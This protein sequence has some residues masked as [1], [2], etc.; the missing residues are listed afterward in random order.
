M[1]WSETFEKLHQHLPF[2]LIKIENGGIDDRVLEQPPFLFGGIL[3]RQSS[4]LDK[5]GL[6]LLVVSERLLVQLIEFFFE[7]E[8]ALQRLANEVV[9][10]FLRGITD[11]ERQELSERRPDHGQR[12]D[13][14]ANAFVE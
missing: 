11:D 4:G 2:V 13:P 7:I 3:S 8:H 6:K 14:G 12:A 5:R 10:T 1:Q 9:A